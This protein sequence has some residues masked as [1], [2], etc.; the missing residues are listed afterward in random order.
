MAELLEEQRRAVLWLTLHRPAQR[1]ALTPHLIA[2]LRQA[3]ARADAEP[4]T[5]VVCLTGS[6][7]QAFCAG[8][9]LD[10]LVRMMQG[11]RPA[12]DEF[13]E[14]IK[15]DVSL[16]YKGLMRSFDVS[17]PIIAAV[18]GYCVAGGMEMLQ[19]TDIRVA[20]EDARFAI[21]EV[22]HGL[23]PMGGS[24]ARL[25]R[26]IPFANAMEI[27]LTGEQFS[28]AD[29]L[30]IGVVN[31]VVPA[32]RVMAEARRFAEVICEN[33]PIAVQAVKRSVLAGL[34]RPTA[35]ALEKELEIGIP[36]SMS[37]DAREGTKAFKEKRK[38]VFKGR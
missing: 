29:A 7:E 16:I 35:E 14:R 12:E 27:L 4:A 2:L 6:G 26:Q 28:A 21:A 19:A 3:L 18:K 5:R 34:G 37:E 20:A 38:P 11:L 25:A 10:R 9:D 1:N 31:R 36:A 8:A 24:T 33:G 23:F 32:A 15:N 30:R 17:K 13:D 22:K